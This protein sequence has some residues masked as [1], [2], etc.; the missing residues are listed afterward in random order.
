MCAGEGKVITCLY[1]NDSRPLPFPDFCTGGW[2]GCKYQ[3]GEDLQFA[4]HKGLLLS[5]NT[6]GL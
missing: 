1:I 6:R 2:K 3:K 5:E 4:T